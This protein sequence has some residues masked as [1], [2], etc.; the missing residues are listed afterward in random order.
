MPESKNIDSLERRKVETAKSETV[1]KAAARLI[2]GSAPSTE[3]ADQPWATPPVI[4][5]GKGTILTDVDGN[6]YVDYACGNG[7]LLLGHGD[8]RIVAAVH[9][10][11]AKGWGFPS[12]TEL[13]VRLAELI[14]GRFAT[15]SMV[16]LVRSRSDAV[17]DAVRLA[18][19][20]TGREQVV[21]V[22]GNRSAPDRNQ[23]RTA[24]V[25]NDPDS[26]A[27]VFH[28]HDA[29]IA[30]VLVDPVGGG[31]VAP[32]IEFLTS[33]RGL[34]DEHGALL[35]MD[36][37]LTG[38]RVSPGGLA[39]FAGISPDLV[40][41]GAAIGGGLP[42]AAFGG[43]KDV[44]QA[45]RISCCGELRDE[46]GLAGD[47]ADHATGASEANALA[48]AAGIATLEA[49]SEPGFQE[50]LE[51]KAARLDEGLRTASAAENAMTD[52]VRVG[53]LVRMSFRSDPERQWT[54]FYRAMLE[55]GV[56]LPPRSSSCICVCAAHTNEE[57][58]RTIETAYDVLRTM[59]GGGNE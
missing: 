3:S 4:A 31:L 39:G 9:K 25:Y 43:R 51:A 33:L 58:D 45:P 20:R 18:R 26:A 17:A 55:R 14:A 56:F 41:L 32:S 42:L 37:T 44:M 2:P 16:R 8:E 38:F 40:C 23:S 49:M 50:N 13:S 52:H 29:T 11:S 46:Q 12:L 54:L 27:D 19:W 6:E 1:R 48:I 47:V 10:A 22:G 36:E 5:K 34:C 24:V 30:A 15:I 57:I 35:I 28:R 7:S 21:T 53:S 59:R